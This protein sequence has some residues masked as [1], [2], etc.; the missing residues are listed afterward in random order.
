MNI[1]ANSKNIAVGTVWGWL[2]LLVI[3]P[4][5]LVFGVSFL[6]I[7]T[8]SFAALP[9]TL[10]NY[11]ELFDS[12]LLKM[13][14][15]SFELAGVSTVI[16]LL[17][18]YPFAWFLAHVS[19]KYRLVLLVLLVVPFWTN[20]L[21]RTYALVAMI[22]A[23]G[24]INKLLMSM[25]LISMPV[26]MLYTRGAV[27]LG[28][29]Y[30][31][32]PFMVLPLYSSIIKL[33]KRLLE[34]GRDLGAGPVRT[35]FKIALPLT[36]PGIV[37]GCMLVFIPALGMFYIPD[38]LGGSKQ[39]LIGNFIKDQ[40]LVTREWP[41]GAAASVFLTTLMACMFVV[42]IISQRKTRKRT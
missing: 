19:K 26:Q 29:C 4:N 39:A 18:G 3:I 22:N 40:F 31:L 16:C 9:F 30:T 25:G 10:E 21:V 6:S 7:D 34:A 1:R 5:L 14:Q 11:K 20:S 42:N 36:L 27:L 17:V 15:R 2:F 8:D 12:S 28:L 37:S 33:D 32:L 23:N 35:F 13:I 41:A 38:I 24:L